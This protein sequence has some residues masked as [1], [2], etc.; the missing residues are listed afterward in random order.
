M[1]IGSIDNIMTGCV[2][3]KIRDRVIPKE[4]I[5]EDEDI[6]AFPDINPVKPIHVLIIP[7]KHIEDFLDVDDGILWNKLKKTTQKIIW[8]ILSTIVIFS[9]VVWTLGVALMK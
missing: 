7:K 1:F 2:F 8:V 6:M 5:F 3:C 4:F 9:M